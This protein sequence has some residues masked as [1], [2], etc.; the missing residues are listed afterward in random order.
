MI[1]SVRLQWRDTGTVGVLIVPD[2]RP[3][4]RNNERKRV[5]VPV[6]STEVMSG[7][8]VGTCLRNTEDKSRG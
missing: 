5:G 4:E 3:E 6:E 8:Y 7:R 1:K 2:R